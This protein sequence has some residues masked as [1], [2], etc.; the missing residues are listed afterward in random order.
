MKKL[1]STSSLRVITD[2][3]SFGKMRLITGLACNLGSGIIKSMSNQIN[4]AE[5][6]TQEAIF[7]S[8][9]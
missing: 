5:S 6:R 2:Y 1:N 4:S 3:V 8:T 7:C 9:I